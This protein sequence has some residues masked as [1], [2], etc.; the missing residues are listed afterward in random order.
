MNKNPKYYE[1]LGR[2]KDGEMMIDY[3]YKKLNIAIAEVFAKA[4]ND[5]KSDGIDKDNWAAT[6]NSI[7]VETLQQ[8]QGNITAHLTRLINLKRQIK[9]IEA[10]NE[11]LK[12]ELTQYMNVYTQEPQEKIG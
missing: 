4:L 11:R 9:D 10:E 6:L 2:I 7:S 8:L 5:T 3:N 12:V 1:I